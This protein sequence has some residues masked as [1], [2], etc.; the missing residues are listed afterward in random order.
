MSLHQQPR[1]KNEDAMSYI[2]TIQ[3]S[4]SPVEYKE[5]L[6][7]MKMYQERSLSTSGVVDRVKSLFMDKEWLILGF[8]RFLP[9]DNRISEAE[10]TR[11]RKLRI[12]ASSAGNSAATAATLSS[13][14]DIPAGATLSLTSG[15]NA[16][17]SLSSSSASSSSSSLSSASHQ[18]SGTN[19][20]SSRRGSMHKVS[21]VGDMSEKS[22]GG[23]A[24][25]EKVSVNRA[26]DYVGRI[27]ARF[28]D[29]PDAYMRF[30]SML[31][32]YQNGVITVKELHQGVTEI[33][34]GHLDLLSEFVSFLPAARAVAGASAAAAAAAANAASK[35]TTG[36]TTAVASGT[37][38][39]GS[40]GSAG[41][42]GARLQGRQGVGAGQPAS[43][44]NIPVFF[45]RVRERL[46]DRRMF[47]ELVKC[48]S[49][50]S[51]QGITK[52]E[53]VDAAE[54][55]L[56]K[57]PDLLSMLKGFLDSD[58]GSLD[59]E[60]ISQNDPAVLAARA[61][62]GPS[63]QLI[64]KKS[65]A[66]TQSSSF[67]SDVTRKVLN[68]DFISMPAGSEDVGGI[69]TSKSQYDEILY[70]CEDDRTE[71]DVVIDQA[72]SALS[73]LEPKAD[74]IRQARPGDLL[75]ISL[76]G[77]RD[78]YC[79]AIH[80]IYGDRG[81]EVFEALRTNP[82]VAIPIVVSR[83]RQKIQEWEVARAELNTFWKEVYEKNQVKWVEN[84]HSMFRTN[85]KRNLTAR[86]FVAELEQRC[87]TNR[88]IQMVIPDDDVHADVGAL[89]LAV[90]RM[91][92]PQ[93]S[94][95]HNA[96]SAILASVNG[97]TGPDT[98]SPST[99]SETSGGSGDG[100][101]TAM[102]TDG[103][104]DGENGEASIPSGDFSRF[105]GLL[106]YMLFFSPMMH[107]DW[108]APDAMARW[109]S[110]RRFLPTASVDATDTEDRSGGPISAVGKRSNTPSSGNPA[111]SVGDDSRDDAP[112]QDDGPVEPLSDDEVPK[113]RI[114][115]KNQSRVED[116]VAEF[117]KWTKVQKDLPTVL[118]ECLDMWTSPPCYPVNLSIP[119][120]QRKPQSA[121]GSTIFYG[122]AQFYVI[123]RLYGILCERLH[124]AKDMCIRSAEEEITHGR[125]ASHG[126]GQSASASKPARAE[127]M[128][129]D[130]D[131]GAEKRPD[132]RASSFVAPENFLSVPAA[133]HQEGI[134]RY[135]ELIRV[136]VDYLR[137]YVGAR[138][139][140]AEASRSC[141]S[142]AFVLFG[143]DKLVLS[144]V[145]HSQQIVHDSM[146]KKVISAFLYERYRASA[147]GPSSPV[148]YL[149]TVA[150]LTAPIF[151]LEFVPK[152]AKV[153]PHISRES[154]PDKDAVD[155]FWM[156][157][158]EHPVGDYDQESLEEKAL[159]FLEEMMCTP[160]DSIPVAKRN[161]F[162]LRNRR[163]HPM[164][165]EYMSS[166]R[167]SVPEEQNT[168]Y[169]HMLASNFEVHNGLE[170]K[171]CMLSFRTIW[172]DGTSDVFLKKKP[173]SKLRSIGRIDKEKAASRLDS[174]SSRLRS[175]GT[176]KTA[177][178]GDGANKQEVEIFEEVED[179]DEAS[180]SSDG[181]DENVPEGEENAEES[182]RNDGDG[183]EIVEGE[184]GV[185]VEGEGEGEDGEENDDGEDDDEEDD[186]EGGEDSSAPA[187]RTLLTIPD[188]A[189]G[190]EED[191]EVEGV[192]DD[193]AVAATLAASFEPEISTRSR[194]RARPLPTD[195]RDPPA[196]RPRM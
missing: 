144:L 178:S 142:M 8:N 159:L 86:Q 164:Y 21:S 35:K 6:G 158:V 98:G 26:I 27:K 28:S 47:Q 169:S 113:R 145:R 161:I 193:E 64:A 82:R 126:V 195:F 44:S 23:E 154:N 10:L 188:A 156:S 68:S 180:E 97:T 191:E 139:Y 184:V 87:E 54:E 130:A 189:L 1:V 30:I 194:T 51:Q 133:V 31:R 2:K 55:I 17:L 63:Y 105:P 124:K 92:A 112:G 141:G 127:P 123:F 11:E 42:G 115:G 9:P 13:V 43:T 59:M 37:G 81:P 5:F 109:K 183:D 196:K 172:V 136:L 152:S 182:V 95:S 106:L 134:R 108:S 143:L 173:V 84:L 72:R 93:Q 34:Q 57:H 101:A 135:R 99:Q 190:A 111:V 65:S 176:G 149:R 129:L 71:L 121:E 40:A 70:T 15:A 52:T 137:G 66:G 100:G 148:V 46:K 49:L 75:R 151:K 117:E 38:S 32:N 165:A 96:V 170:F 118:G 168:A 150:K 107:V 132:A 20:S 153:V 160:I 3:S 48:L 122:S 53:L 179:D 12:A 76:S 171:L 102:V 60:E 85:E 185:E 177:A 181:E 69:Y 50:Y 73:F 62:Y 29:Q 89:Y 67:A 120:G 41:P 116:D 167:S 162:L 19:A 88:G 22:S 78:I 36:S 186:E 166:R 131:G 103:G 187:P 110:V 58:E 25:G 91:L 147:L 33:F 146:C 138:E 119:E 90:D 114:R 61:L 79:A 7:I 174:L 125:D 24:T 155:S 45:D 77:M 80:R 39:T 18:N 175:L 16:S 192:I 4:V 104:G 157:I 74:L 56:G 83:L 128:V 163:K 94:N 14:A 140:E